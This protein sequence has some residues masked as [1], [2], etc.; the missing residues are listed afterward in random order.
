MNK[1][2]GFKTDEFYELFD[3][4]CMILNERLHIDYLSCL[5]RVGKDILYQINDQKL[6]DED[7]TKLTNI[8]HKINQET[9]MNEEIR[10]AMELLVVKA[11]KHIGYSLDLMTPDYVCYLFAYFI[12]KLM[13]IEEDNT[14]NTFTMLDVGLGTSNLSN[15]IS[16]YL[17]CDI[18]RIGVEKDQRLVELSQIFSDLQGND[19]K[20]YY[21][22]YLKEITDLCSIVIGDLDDETVDDKYL[23]YEVICHYNNNIK[24]DGYFLYMIPNNFFNNEHL[25]SFKQ[26]FKGTLLGLVVL[27]QELFQKNHIGKSILIGTSQYISS[28][29][30]MVV[31]MPIVQK[32]NEFHET[33]KK[34]EKWIESLEE[35]I[36]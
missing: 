29:D 6:E 20:I 10:Q 11:F 24:E 17:P 4:A 34:I 31:Q 21:Q 15:A 3:Q 35:N 18:N 16:N 27:P 9:F 33:L 8:Y 26:N 19:I 5:I 25:P 30:M 13:K 2:N 23:P 32:Q 14:I 28:F 22:D 1:T 7:I 12:Q 36:K